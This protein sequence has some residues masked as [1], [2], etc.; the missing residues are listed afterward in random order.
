MNSIEH[1]DFRMAHGEVGA[2][3]PVTPQEKFINRVYSSLDEAIASELDRLRSGY[4]VIPTCARGCS[5][6]CRDHIVTNVAEAHALAQYVKREF[7]IDQISSLRM[8]TKQW[9]E[10]NDYRPGLYPPTDIRE[11]TDFSNYDPCCPLL[12]D[13]A[14]SAYPVRPVVC[15]THY[16]SSH[17]RFC[18]EANV[19]GS[20]SPHPVAITSVVEETRQF[21]VAIRDYIE[22]AGWDFSRSRML[23]PYW[24]ATQLGWDFA[25]TP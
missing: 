22:S 20:T 25:I 3:I 15:R 14:C 1:A 24:L 16:I 19:Q 4:G 5:Y 21:L 13:G 7:S 23:L 8:R 18:R 12:V 17:P 9:H 2:D 10:W 6:C 11:Q